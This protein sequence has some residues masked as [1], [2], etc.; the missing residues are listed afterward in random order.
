M[1]SMTNKNIDDIFLFDSTPSKSYTVVTLGV[2]YVLGLVG[3]I[4]LWRF[5]ITYSKGL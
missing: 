3:V 5:N 4:E 2:G 1:A